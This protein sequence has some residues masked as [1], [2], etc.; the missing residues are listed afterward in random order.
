MIIDM[1][2]EKPIKHKKIEGVE[3]AATERFGRRLLMEVDSTDVYAAFDEVKKISGGEV[4]PAN[5]RELKRMIED[6]PLEQSEVLEYY[7]DTFGDFSDEQFDHMLT[8][9]QEGKAHLNSLGE[10]SEEVKSLVHIVDALYEVVASQ[11]STLGSVDHHVPGTMTK[12]ELN[13]AIE[14]AKN[15]NIK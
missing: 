2:I 13:D 7:S 15:V 3:N 14:Q 8:K 5:M 12:E 10:A 4:L 6:V 9:L 1:N 11:H